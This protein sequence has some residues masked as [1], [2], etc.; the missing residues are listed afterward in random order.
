MIIGLTMTLSLCKFPILNSMISSS[1]GIIYGI[2]QF[3]AG[4]KSGKY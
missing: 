4:N 2:G 3:L 1:Y